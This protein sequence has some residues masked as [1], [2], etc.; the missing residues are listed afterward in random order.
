MRSSFQVKA[1]DQ[2]NDSYR[3]VHVEDCE[4]GHYVQ[5]DI[6]KDFTEVFCGIFLEA[7][8]ETCVVGHIVGHKC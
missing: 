1:S 2:E 8:T 3:T 4:S 6:P 5:K 7:V